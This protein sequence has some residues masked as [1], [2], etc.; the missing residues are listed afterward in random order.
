[1]AIELLWHQHQLGTL[2]FQ[3]LGHTELLGL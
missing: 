2:M 1:M 3:H